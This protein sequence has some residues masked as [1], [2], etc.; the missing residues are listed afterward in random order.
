MVSKEINL[1]CKINEEALV[2]FRRYLSANRDAIDY[3]HDQRGV[4]WEMISQFQLGWAG[5]DSL[6][7]YSY[8]SK[9]YSYQEL[10]SSGLFLRLSDG[11]VDRF[12]NR[13]MFP[14]VLESGRVVGFTGRIIGE[15]NPKYMNSPATFAYNKSRILYG[16][17]MTK[18]SIMKAK[19]AILVEGNL[20]L[21]SL[22]QNDVI[23]VV[24]TCGTAL[25]EYHAKRLYALADEVVIAYDADKAGRLARKKAEE[26]LKIAGL[27]VRHLEFP[28]GYDPDKFIKEFGKEKFLERI[29]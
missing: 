22:F 15:G 10:A 12:I 27:K 24:A 19:Q 11:L 16:L 7:L 21:I 29:K 18:Y 14:I 6:G 13:L 23:N 17:D 28:E 9:D 8:L 5:N 1:A 3:I 4:S 26:I 20:D 25:T 2:Y